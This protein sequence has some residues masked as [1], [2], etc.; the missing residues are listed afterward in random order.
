MSVAPD[1]GQI[2]AE[3]A[4]VV[5]P[6]SIMANAPLNVF[7]LGLVRIWKLDTE[8]HVHVTLSPTSPSCTLIGSIMTGIEE[9]V[10]AVP[11]VRSVTVELDGDTMWTMNLMTEDGRSK[12]AGRREG[13]AKRVPLRPQQWRETATTP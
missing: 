13:S 4:L 2:E 1:E 12:L 7:E 10:A 6:C 3:M 9:R 11:G 5:D 8:G